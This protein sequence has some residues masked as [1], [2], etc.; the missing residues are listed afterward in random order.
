VPE[1]C[2]LALA[3][4]SGHAPAEARVGADACQGSLMS[5]EL[6]ER[7]LHGQATATAPAAGA[8]GPARRVVSLTSARAGLSAALPWL[9]AHGVLI[10]G[11][12]SVI[13]PTLVSL[14]RWSWSTD[15]GAH[16]PIVLAT[17]MWLLWRESGGLRA[18]GRRMPLFPPVLSL[19]TLLPIYVFGRVVNVLAIEAL[20]LWAILVVLAY[21]QFGPA[22]KRVWFPIVYLLFLVTPP[23]NVLFVAT[24]PIKDALSV[25]VVDLLGWLGFAVART[26]VM[27]QIDGYQLLVATA[28][29]GIN[30]LIGITAVGLLYIHL[31]RGSDPRY[32]LL[33]TALVLPIA[34]AANFVRIILLV[35]MTHYFGESVAQG[36]FHELTGLGIFLLSLLLLAALDV[37]LQPI[38]RRLQ[39]RQSA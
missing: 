38:A 9:R 10:A 11:L 13:V 15:T 35:L 20:S 18:E 2:K 32:A 27:I 17:G 3:S 21:L 39:R 30:S 33:L 19:V 12:L 31:L 25:A 23:E 1:R 29:S 8:P 5:Q 7:S 24:R 37:V 28:C 22:L 26:G 36:V 6:L 16:G 14:G 34:V 4:G